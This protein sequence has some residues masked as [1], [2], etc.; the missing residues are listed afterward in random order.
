MSIKNDK[1]QTIFSAL[2]TAGTRKELKARTPLKFK[3][4]NAA[5]VQVYLNG[6]LID[7]RSYTRANV[8]TF[9]VN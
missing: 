5:G 6:Q 8:A 4:G 3:I 9:E 7:Q 2:S 1:G